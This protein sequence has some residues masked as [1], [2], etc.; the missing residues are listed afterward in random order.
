MCLEY[1]SSPKQKKAFHNTFDIISFFLNCFFFKTLCRLLF[2]FLATKFGCKSHCFCIGPHS[3]K[4]SDKKQT[5][6]MAEI[7][8]IARRRSGR[9]LT[10]IAY[11]YINYSRFY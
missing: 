8:N 3:K 7:D 6:F 5:K 9:N 10:A 1:S 2:W 11:K 4:R